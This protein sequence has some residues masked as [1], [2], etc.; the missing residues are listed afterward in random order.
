MPYP[1]FIAQLRHRLTQPLPGLDAQMTM[2]PPIRG[3]KVFVPPNVRKSAVMVLLYP[4]QGS[5][6]IPF[7]RRAKDGRVH[8]GQVSFP[9]GRKEPDDP[10]FTYTALRETHEEFGI[11]P[12]QVEILGPLTELF[13]PP[14]NSLVYPRVGF[15]PHRPVFQPD[16]RE[17]AGI[18]EVPVDEFFNPAVRANHQV[19]VFGGH[20]I[21]APGYTVNQQHLI[22]GATAMMMAEFTSVLAELPSYS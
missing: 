13:I 22:W 12:E 17:V 20:Y 11:P 4:H 9:G 2:S 7:M 15:M 5:W 16:E 8:S 14:S 19:E 18:I 3:R 10:D 6:Y 21:E 1:D